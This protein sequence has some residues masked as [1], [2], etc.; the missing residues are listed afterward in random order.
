LSLASDY[1]LLYHGIN[2]IKQENTY[3]VIKNKEKDEFFN[4]IA[5]ILCAKRKDYEKFITL[6]SFK[7]LAG[8]ITN[9]K[10]Q[11]LNELHQLQFCIIKAIESDTKNYHIE[12]MHES[13]K[14][15]KN[16]NIIT[17]SEYNKLISL[18]NA[19]ELMSYDNKIDAQNKLNTEKN[20][21]FKEAKSKLTNIILELQD[22]INTKEYKKEIELTSSYLNNQKFSIGVTGV[23]NAGKSTMLNALMSEEI[24]GS[25]V[26]PET[27]NLTII[28]Y[29][30]PE[31]KV[32]YW[33]KKEWRKIENLASTLEPI[34][35]FVKE[36]KKAFGEN[37]SNLI[38]E[39]SLSE[40]IDI[41]NLIKYTS[42]QTSHKKCNL[43]KYVE[44]K[45]NLNFLK[46]G[47]EIVDTPGLD[48]PIIQR[49][50]I[51]K[52][53]L[54]K[55]D[56]MLHLM[57]VS[58]SATLKDVEFIID[59]I[60]Y[61]NV[62]KL[63]IV[64]TRA[65][66]VSKK[67]LE[68][69]INYT[70]SSIQ[71]QL[72][73]QNKNNKLEYILNTIKFIPTSGKMALLHRIGKNEQAIQ[74]GFNIKDTGILE[75]EKFLDETLFG[76]NSS[77]SDLIIKSTKNQLIKII[78]KEKKSFNYE[79][80][81]LSKSKEELEANLKE[82]NKAK[83]VNKKIFIAMNEDIN[84]YKKD[85]KIYID[86]LDTF[87]SAELIDL[88]NIIKQ[89][90]F[91][92]VKYS[93]EK[94]NKKPQNSRIKAIIQ[95]AIKD[96]IIDIIRDYR[97]KFIK[98]AQNIGEIFEQ[99]YQD[100]GFTIGHENDN[101]NARDFFQDDFKKGF[102][103]SSNEILISKILNEINKSNVK[104]FS[105][106][107]RNIEKHIKKEFNFVE[108]TI[109]GKAKSISQ[110]LIDNFFKCITEPL[111]TFQYKLKKDEEF[112]QEKI[113][114][115]EKNEKN[116]DTLT[117]EIHKKIKKLKAISKGLKS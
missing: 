9:K 45:S 40:Q 12:K 44:L 89:R 103:T 50:E 77:K 63:L 26:V 68:E 1:F 18:F 115:F 90:V 78:E 28:K 21:S 60:L 6:E 34:G 25:A 14:Y 113:K 86:T 96:G 11:N 81:L 107:N 67:Q 74:A 57:N 31:A 83:E 15:L 20:I 95:T 48:D 102:L 97:Y 19:E 66:T 69:V 100:L 16:E 56:L 59:A 41:N 13:F 30:K 116:K 22:I 71:T 106:L 72:K 117:I 65:D 92:D 88:Q 46:D 8:K 5:L 98:K 111:K 84:L 35:E 47:I 85:A 109:K 112:L 55:C 87:L 24:L 82:L 32:F 101:F 58:Q 23:M 70:K 39:K 61:Q 3:S 2:D 43:I 108:K 76:V 54:V 73:L 114:N 110:L 37:L 29:G 105:Q 52:E 17:T 10:V 94:T 27:A 42:V 51:T 93:C 64:I 53:Y 4:I 99:K 49:E 38:K 7:V 62:T 75:I 80:L 104:K 91:N 36:T 33:N 79:L